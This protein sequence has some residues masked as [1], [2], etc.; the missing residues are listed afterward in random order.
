MW[1]SECAN[2]SFVLTGHT[3]ANIL[4][5]MNEEEEEMDLHR[6]NT[7]IIHNHFIPGFFFL[8]SSVTFSKKD[9]NTFTGILGF[10]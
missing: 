10:V 6:I 4:Y 7:D 1:Q 2:T 8:R 3:A 5:R 9:T